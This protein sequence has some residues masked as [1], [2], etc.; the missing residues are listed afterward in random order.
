MSFI[1]VKKDHTFAQYGYRES[2]NLPNTDSTQ[3]QYPLLNVSVVNPLNG[4]VIPVIVSDSLPYK[5]ASIA[6]SQQLYFGYRNGSS[7]DKLIIDSH[8]FQTG[9]NIVG[10][11]EVLVDYIKTDHEQ[12]EEHKNKLRLTELQNSGS[13]LSGMCLADARS[14]AVRIL[15]ETG[16][17]GT[18]ASHC[19]QDWLISRQ[20]LAYILV[21]VLHSYIL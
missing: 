11:G 16:R 2:E 5:S 17:G 3:H 4:D 19:Q 14:A 20:V 7:L 10:D 21:S 1:G 13:I 8:K 12:N 9:E 6:H 15:Q 18:P